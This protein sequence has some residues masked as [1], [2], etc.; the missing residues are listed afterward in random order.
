LTLLPIGIYDFGINI[1][2]SIGIGRHPFSAARSPP[3]ARRCSASGQR[4]AGFVASLTYLAPPLQE[5]VRSIH[6]SD[7]DVENM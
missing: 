6:L 2:L 1:E 5:A 3:P 4:P 7:I